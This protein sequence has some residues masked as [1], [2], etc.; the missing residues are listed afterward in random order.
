MT[1]DGYFRTGDIG[2]MEPDGQF[3][4]SDRKKDMILVSGFNVYPNEV[5]A[6]IAKLPG[7]V[8]CACVGTTDERCGEAV[9]AFVV[10]EDDA[11]D[12]QRIDEHCRTQLASYKV[13][14]TRS[15]PGRATEKHRGQG[16]APRATQAALT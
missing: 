5:E 12:E 7:V 11:V 14:K 13:P 1:D 10:R 6:A 9:V 16:L 2:H 15:L 3:V 8:E 4:I